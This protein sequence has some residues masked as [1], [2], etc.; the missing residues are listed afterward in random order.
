VPQLRSLPMY[1]WI[2][3][4]I[5]AL[6][7]AAVFARLEPSYHWHT[8]IAWTGYILLADAFVWKRRGASWL[9]NNPAELF[10]LACASVPLWVVFEIYNKY[11]LRNWYYIGLPDNSTL[12]AFGYIWSF[13]TI[14]P[15]IFETAD[16]V[17]SIRDRR[18][19][20]DRTETPAPRPLGAAGWLSVAA[21][22]VMLIAPFVLRSSPIATYLAAPVWL[23]FILVLDPLNAR[24]GSE[25]ILGDWRKHR[26]SR[27]TNLL[28]AGLLCG[29]LWEF[30]N[31][32]SGTKWF[33][34]V[35]ILPSVKI[36]EMPVLGF[37]GFPPFA[38]ECFV[39][40]VAVR[41]W[42]WRFAPRPVAV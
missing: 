30:W 41:R 37:G 3:A 12:R 2:G 23:G 29:F 26:T 17:S 34:N 28:A 20:M 16:V 31:Y 42:L 35:P 10:F 1:G 21:G 13:A 7:Q 40:Y 33:Y 36:F 14:W 22:G 27:L 38:V 11:S 25:S 9:R 32:W 15:A 24:A 5:V 18:A 8:P 4:L 6:S 39:M 19:P